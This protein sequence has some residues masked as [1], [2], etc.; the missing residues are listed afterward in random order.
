MAIR[1]E[2]YRSEHEL[3]VAEFNRR[4]QAG[5]G[6]PNLVFSKSAVPVWLSPVPGANVWN[7]FFVAVEGSFIRGAYALKHEQLFVRGRGAQ[8][9]ACY[10]HALSEGVI[11]RAYASVGGLL[12]RDAI[13]RQPHLYALGMGGMEQPLAR[14][15]KLLGFTLTAVPLYFHVV[16][17]RR[18]LQ[19]MQVLRE[20]RWRAV[21]MDLAAWSGAGW[22]AIKL[23]QALHGSRSGSDEYTAEHFDEFSSWADELWD[24]TKDHASAAFLRDSK[25]LRRLYPHELSKVKLLSVTQRQQRVGW[26]AMGKRRKDDKFGNLRVGSI[27]DCWA[28]PSGR[29]GIVQAATKA[30]A[31]EGV[32]LIVS[33]QAHSG[34]GKAFESCGYFRGPSNFVFATSRRLSALLEPLEQ[35]RPLFHLTRADGD[36]LP[37]NF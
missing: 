31:S 3:A 2:P 10:H 19:E 33:N 15:L 17:P 20:K 12:I 23:G 22:L 26:A 8:P 30:L 21:L 6:D 24:A 35:N 7:E 37:A 18:F 29:A 32:D 11:N 14:M 9:V 34:W 36:G 27:V 13:A 16:H 1:I 5:S 25:T 4:M 28:V